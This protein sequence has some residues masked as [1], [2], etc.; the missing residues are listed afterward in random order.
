MKKILAMIL[1]TVMLLSLAVAAFAEEPATL[2]LKNGEIQTMVSKDDVAQAIAVRGNEIVYVGDDA[3]VE[4]FIGDGTQVIDL[5]GQYVLPG[6]IDG[7]IHSA[8]VFLSA[9]TE[10]DLMG[11][12]ANLEVYK[13]AVKEFVEAHPDFEIYYVNA[14]DLKAFPESTGENSWLDDICSE[15]PICCVDVSLHGRLLNTKAIEMC[16]ITKDTER[17]RVFHDY[18]VNRELMQLGNIGCK[19][20]HP[21]PATRGEDVTDEVAD[22][23]SSLC[24]LEAGNRLTAIS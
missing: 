2:V 18:Q 11:L 5:N 6:F 13:A 20:M 12:D 21:L 16:G 22:S 8:S 23:E 3:G 4:A 15:K 9:D 24:W 17:V 19:F 1:S 10:L 14:L 7:H